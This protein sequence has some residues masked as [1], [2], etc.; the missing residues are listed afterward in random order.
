MR[1]FASIDEIGQSVCAELK[2]LGIPRSPECFEVWFRH[3]QGAN[4]D[5]SRDINEQRG[6]GG[7]IDE[8]FILSL[9]YRY[10][11]RVDL[12]P[13]FDRYFDRVLEEVE[14]LKGV[15]Q[16]LSD[17]SRTFGADVQSLS[18]DIAHKGASQTE[19]RGLIAALV[20]TAAAATKRNQNLESKL[21]SAVD[22]ISKL[23]NSIEE[24]E[25]DALTDFLTKLGNRR[26]FDKFLREA[27]A[28]AEKDGARLSLIVCDIDHFKKFND[29]FGHQ[30]GDHVIKFV[31]DILKK[32]IKGQD[33]AARYGGE[34][35]AIALP[36]TSLWN[37]QKLAEK[38]RAAI[39]KKKLVNR[40]GNQDLGSITMSFGVAE[41][42]P[43]MSSE[44]F[45]EEADA[46]LLDAKRSGRN[47]VV[48]RETLRLRTA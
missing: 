27:F 9:Y 10:C 22:S 34:E 17:S 7:P 36:N 28:A 29:A 39:A 6:C 32:N 1:T 42:E 20:E 8:D 11:E 41:Y 24:I 45:F 4:A 15:A 40:T 21:S 37:A 44:T 26:R 12:A 16:G 25:E 5:L 23:R 38:I 18:A 3:L 35:F 19:L 13:V 2:A 48:V 47:K 33:L 30:V 14:G 31:A 43:G 46:A